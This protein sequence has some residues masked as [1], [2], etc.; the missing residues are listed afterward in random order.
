MKIVPIVAAITAL[1]L[2][3]FIMASAE[4]DID[5][6][7][8]PL[9]AKNENAFIPSNCKIEQTADSDLNGDGR[10]DKALL[11]LENENPGEAGRFINKQRLL[12][13]LLDVGSSG[14]KRVGMNS[15]IVLGTQEGG[16]KGAFV[17]TS[18][19][20]GVLIV[21][22][23][24]GSADGWS[25]L[26]RFRWNKTTGKL[27]LIGLDRWGGNSVSGAIAVSESTNLL[28]H[29]C[30]REQFKSS[31]KSL[32]DIRTSCKTTISKRKTESLDDCSLEQ[33]LND[34]LY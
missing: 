16:V 8:I 21:K 26:M 31:N 24:G 5:R 23:A 9:T 15:A 11:L 4:A 25:E 3:E 28:T 10:P 29:K 13:V 32:F 20:D 19:K 34:P 1:T 27:M 2:P 7:K 6:S 17:E 12:L 33:L 14:Y 22:N 30:I 18:I